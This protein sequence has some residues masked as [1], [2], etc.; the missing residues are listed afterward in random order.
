MLIQVDTNTMP[1][2]ESTNL[3]LGI[4]PG[5]VE[6][7]LRS[8]DWRM[9]ENHNKSDHVS[10]YLFVPTKLAKI[11]LIVERLL[12]VPCSNKDRARS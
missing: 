5:H 9:L 1:A 11:D 10:Y 4:E 6:T 2:A 7:D 8:Y 12:R 3:K